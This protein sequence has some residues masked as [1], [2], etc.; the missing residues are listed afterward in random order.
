MIMMI[1]VIIII[2]IM[3]MENDDN[4]YNNTNNDS[5]KTLIIKMKKIMIQTILYWS[6]FLK[7]RFLQL[8]ANG[9]GMEF[10]TFKLL[11]IP[12]QIDRPK[13]KMLF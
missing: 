11:Q 1:M 9:V 12:L 13:N 6:K 5:M 10:K 8:W 4:C 7:S 3:I 2:I